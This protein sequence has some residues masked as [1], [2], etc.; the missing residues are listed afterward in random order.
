MHRRIC[1]IAPAPVRGD[2][3]LGDSLEEVSFFDRLRT[4]AKDVHQEEFRNSGFNEASESAIEGLYG[5]FSLV[6]YFGHDRHKH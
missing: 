1:G 4:F 6:V 2:R 3:T 5:E